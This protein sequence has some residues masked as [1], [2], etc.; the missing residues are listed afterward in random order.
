MMGVQRVKTGFRDPPRHIPL[1]PV[2][3]LIFDDKRI[4]F[5]Q[6]CVFYSFFM[7]SNGIRYSNMVPDQETRPL[8][9]S[10]VVKLRPILNQ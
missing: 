8:Y 5:V 1:L 9:P 4:R 10:I 7:I 2:F 6:Q 3:F